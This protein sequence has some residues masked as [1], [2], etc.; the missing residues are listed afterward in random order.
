[1]WSKAFGGT[2]DY[3]KAAGEN[4]SETNAVAEIRFWF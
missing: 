1:M 3:L 2:E 4:T